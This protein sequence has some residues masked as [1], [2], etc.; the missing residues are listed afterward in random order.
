[1]SEE[2]APLYDVK[3]ARS[4]LWTGLLVG[5]ASLFLVLLSTGSSLA[6]S[7]N[8]SGALMIL[9]GVGM[10]GFAVSILMLYQCFRVLSPID[11]RFYGA[12][13]TAAL[14]GVLGAFVYSLY[15]FTLGVGIIGSSTGFYN[16][17]SVLEGLGTPILAF[18]A[19]GVGIAIRK[20]VSSL[21]LGE[22]AGIAGI[23]YALTGMP[24]I[25]IPSA[26][27]ALSILFF[28]F[29]PALPSP[30]ILANIPITSPPEEE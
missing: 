20:S 27:I 4:R 18:G 5:L 19:A 17:A 24:V 9:A 15:Y 12:A 30:E 8:L 22:E 16:A 1:M 6:F 3:D 25:G 26:F 7:K 14:I 23:L 29:K 13:G 11:A 21:R 28:A 2:K 10:L